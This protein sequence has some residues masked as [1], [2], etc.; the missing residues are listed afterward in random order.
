VTVE[1]QLDENLM[2]LAKV[3]FDRWGRDEAITRVAGVVARNRHLEAIW[4]VNWILYFADRN[5][6][7][8]A[9]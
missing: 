4:L 5:T 3:L 9:G 8:F 1:N 2:D 7:C 6:R